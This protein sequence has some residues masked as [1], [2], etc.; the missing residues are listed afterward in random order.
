MV[1]MPRGQWSLQRGDRDLWGAGPAG[2]G[3]WSQREEGDMSRRVSPRS[4]SVRR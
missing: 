3:E 1:G 4:S 2:Q